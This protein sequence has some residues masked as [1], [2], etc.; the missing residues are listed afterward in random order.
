MG[1]LERQWALPHTQLHI[2][3]WSWA[4]SQ[5]W[6]EALEG[7]QASLCWVQT[8]GIWMASEN[9]DLTQPLSID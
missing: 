4:Q 9:L 6:K 1:K 3:S 5:L 8:S 7:D 2:V